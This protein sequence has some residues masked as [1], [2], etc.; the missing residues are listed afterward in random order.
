MGRFRHR[1]LRFPLLCRAG[2][3]V[4]R[5]TDVP[6]PSPRAA[7]PVARR[8]GDLRP[9]RFRAGTR[10]GRRIGAAL[11]R[12]AGRGHGRCDTRRRRRGDLRRRP[13]AGA[14]GGVGHVAARPPPWGTRGGRR[15]LAAR[16]MQPDLPLPA[17]AAHERRARG[18][19]LDRGARH[20]PRPRREQPRR[21][22]PRARRRSRH[23]RRDHDAA[24]PDAAGAHPGPA[25]LALASRGAG[26]RRGRRAG[27]RRGG[28]SADGRLRLPAA[29]RLRRSQPA[30]QRRQRRHQSRELPVVDG[31]LTHA[32][33]GRRPARAARGRPARRGRCWPS[34]WAS[35]RPI[36]RTSP[37][38]TGGTRASCSGR[39]PRWSS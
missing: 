14:L 37:S 4:H 21:C 16:R 31:L 10:P 36:C 22:R 2:P 12:R 27:S 15:V 24:E 30:L 19:A 35:L 34:F 5:G 38:P 13:G 20:R 18:R 1:R 7:G 39:C 17:R 3:D 6:G 32:R 26:H 11:P 25:G 23:E 28:H 29:I 8:G 33:A 9:V